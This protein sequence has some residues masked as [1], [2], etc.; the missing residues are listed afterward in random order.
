MKKGI[1]LILAIILIA[2]GYIIMQEINTKPQEGDN[3][4]TETNIEFS[5]DLLVEEITFN[6]ENQI[7]KYTVRN[8]TRMT[9]EYGAVFTVMKLDDNNTLIETDLTDDLAFDMM[10]RNVEEGESFS[11]EVLFNLFSKPINSGTYYIIRE[12]RDSNGSEH[13]PEISFKVDTEGIKPNR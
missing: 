8:N 9:L 11:D 2:T 13:I 10:L 5:E 3:P 4:D 7:L 12:Y 1:Y 6:E